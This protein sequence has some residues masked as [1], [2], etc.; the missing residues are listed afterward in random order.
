ME[1]KQ[2]RERREEKRNKMVAEVQHYRTVRGE[3]LRNL[4]SG[5]YSALGWKKVVGREENRE[6]VKNDVFV[7]IG[8]SSMVFVAE[9][10][11]AEREVKTIERKLLVE[12]VKVNHGNKN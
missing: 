1:K 4:F 12:L 3:D 10:E 6:Y 5:A 9:K 8:H 7:S 11:E 2:P